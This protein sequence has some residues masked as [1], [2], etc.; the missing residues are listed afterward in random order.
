MRSDRNADTRP[1][2]RPGATGNRLWEPRKGDFSPASPPSPGV[3]LGS[4]EGS[5]PRQGYFYLSTSLRERGVT[6][7]TVTERGPEKSGSPIPRRSLGSDAGGYGGGTA[8][9]PLGLSPRASRTPPDNPSRAR[10]PWLSHPGPPLPRPAES[11]PT[12]FGP[13]GTHVPCSQ[14]RIPT[15]CYFPARTTDHG[16]RTTACED[17]RSV[18]PVRVMRGW[19]ENSEILGPGVPSTPTSRST[20]DS[21][22]C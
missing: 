9:A 8:R 21:A 19:S 2:Y 7:V 12:A 18:G 5:G 17:G 6:V 10:D 1:G 15:A 11:L 20:F 22:T 3:T 14:G 16:S 4:I 13:V